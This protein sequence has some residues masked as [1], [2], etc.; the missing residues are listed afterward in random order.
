[1]PCAV[2]LLGGKGLVGAQTGHSGNPACA[3]EDGE[4][5]PLKA[6]QTG[7]NHP[8][9]HCFAQPAGGSEAVAGAA[10]AGLQRGEGALLQ[11]ELPGAL[12]L[13]AVLLRLADDVPGAAAQCAGQGEG[14]SFQWDGPQPR[15]QQQPVIGATGV[16]PM[17]EADFRGGICPP[18]Q[19]QQGV[20]MDGPA[21]LVSAPQ[22]ARSASS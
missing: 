17:G 7:F 6:G 1:M 4:D 18:A 20:Q 5:V 12:G 11:P 21:V 2:S 16:G 22:T 15:N 9:F 19:P 10:G 8:F 3:V 13:A 14:G